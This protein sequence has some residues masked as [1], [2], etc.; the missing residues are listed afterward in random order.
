MPPYKLTYDL[1]VSE[2][3]VT[4]ATVPLCGA[5]FSLPRSVCSRLKPNVRDRQTDVRRTSSLNASALWVKIKCAILLLGIGG[6][7]ISLSKAMSP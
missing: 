5:N 2:S 1:V 4:W 7:L 6:V 3:R